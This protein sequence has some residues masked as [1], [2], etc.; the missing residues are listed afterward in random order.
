M[1]EEVK[2]H[3]KIKLEPKAEVENLAPCKVRIKVEIAG[4]KI[5]EL[6]E[7]KFAELNQ[8]ISVPGFRRGHAPKSLL[9]K[10]YGK[11]V[12]ES[13]K[14]EVFEESFKEVLEEKNIQPVQQL[15]EKMVKDIE[16]KSNEPFVYSLELETRPQIDVKDYVG[17]KVKKPKIE[18]TDQQVEEFLKA[19]ADSKSEWVP[20]EDKTVTMND[21]I[22]C[23]LFLS[24]DGKPS[25]VEENS[26][27]FI[28]DK[29]A[30]QNVLLPDFHKAVIG[31][32]VDETASY[33]T[34]F[35]EGIANKS[36]AGKNISIEA[37]IKSVKRKSVP[38]IDDN[39]AKSVGMNDLNDLKEESRKTVISM[40][41]NDAKQLMVDDI[42]SILL[43]SNNFEL[44]EGLVNDSKEDSLQNRRVSLI[45]EGL[46][47]EEVQKIIEKEEQGAHDKIVEYL[48]TTFVLENIANKEKIYATE[49][50]V[51]R[52]IEEIASRRGVWPNELR[53]YFESQNMML[54]L[55]INLRKEKV[56]DFLLQ[57]SVA[58]EA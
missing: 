33:S 10:K 45:S 3:Q 35:E 1:T 46:S 26:N 47:E 38:A 27:L 4:S 36:L 8:T 50:D 30:M 9:E 18:I 41:E 37:K 53:E 23:D 48:K 28:T 56:L 44:P 21:Q 54:L 12:L 52:R 55:R 7:S 14:W 31:K 32:K 15:D 49:D 57:N 11:Q 43:K 42:I 13:L 20:A 39:L 16:I 19:V 51:T 58:E 24:M 6:V 17:I 29:I 40:K 5:G 25:L 2:E 34:K 22:I